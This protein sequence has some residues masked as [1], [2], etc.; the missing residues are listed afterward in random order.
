MKTIQFSG[1]EWQ[2]RQTASD[3]GGSRN[4][5]DAANA[6]TDEHGCMH[7]RIAG[8]PRLDQC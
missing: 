7:L 8:Q 5:Y 6:W 1:Y 2:I 4:F 3:P